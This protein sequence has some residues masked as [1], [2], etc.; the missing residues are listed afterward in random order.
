V[1]DLTLWENAPGRDAFLRMTMR[2]QSCARRAA[3]FGVMAA[4]YPVTWRIP[5]GHRPTVNDAVARLDHLREHGDG[6]RAFDWSHLE[7]AELW[8]DARCGAIAAE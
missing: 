3:W 5:K 1:A 7:E 8:R 4:M 6:D 2:R